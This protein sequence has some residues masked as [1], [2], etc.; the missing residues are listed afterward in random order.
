MTVI[1]SLESTTNFLVPITKAL[2]IKHGID[3]HTIDNGVKAPEILDLIKQ[4]KNQTTVIFMG[5]GASHCVYRP[6]DERGYASPLINSSNIEVLK[7]KNFISLSCRS[8]E[9]V[10]SMQVHLEESTLIGFGDL[11]TYWSDIAAVREFDANAYNGVND[12]VLEEFREIIV[13]SFSKSLNDT[14]A[15]GHTFQY[16]YYRFKLYV[17]KFL[18]SVVSDINI[19]PVDRSILGNLL[20]DLK[21]QVILLGNPE[22]W[23][24]PATTHE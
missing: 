9:F 13:D 16:L 19:S 15:I 3:L 23:V 5:H 2:D 10:Q 21:D 1:H 7:G 11:P 6:S 8:A 20:Y 18:S 4:K 14:I 17:N 12:V 24:I 22:A